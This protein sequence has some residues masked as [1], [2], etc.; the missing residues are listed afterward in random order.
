MDDADLVLVTAATTASTAHVVI[1][2]LRE[3]HIAAGLLRLRVFRPFPA[4]LIRTILADRKKV[5]ILDRNC[6]FG[7]HGI[8]HQ[9]VKSALYDLSSGQQPDVHGVIA[10]LGGRDVRAEDLRNMLTGVWEGRITEPVT[11]WNVLESKDAEAGALA[12][13]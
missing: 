1:D 12:M 2:A 11:W 3:D 6:S 9:E 5:V 8:F 4:E 7:H 10:G 13:D